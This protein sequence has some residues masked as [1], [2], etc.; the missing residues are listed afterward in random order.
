MR[1]LWAML[2]IVT[3]SVVAGY[4][5]RAAEDKGDKKV[6][7]RV[8]EMRTYYAAPGK[9]DALNAR[10]R[11]HTTKLFEKFRWLPMEMP[12]PGAADVSAK[13]WVLAVLA[14]ETP[15][16]S[17]A[18]S[19]KLRAFRGRSWISLS[20]TVP[21]ISLRAASSTGASDG[22]S[23]AVSGTRP[24]FSTARRLLQALVVT[25]P[26]A[27]TAVASR[28]NTGMERATR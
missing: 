3:G 15:G 27:R 13:S 19:R 16:T 7:T 23:S 4:A 18:R 26:N 22:S 28:W 24:G 25:M 14:G 5:V 6:D 8:F 17:S 2:I 1:S 20:E 21:A 10:F 12:W 11:N 9:L